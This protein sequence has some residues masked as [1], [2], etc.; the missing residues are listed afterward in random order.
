MNNIKKKGGT[1][2]IK[3]SYKTLKAGS[4]TNSNK[5]SRSQN[6]KRRSTG[7]RVFRGTFVPISK[8]NL[9]KLLKKKIK[10]LALTDDDLLDYDDHRLEKIMT[11]DDINY[12]EL[13]QLRL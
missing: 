5:N 9:Q 7:D 12:I 4:K 8:N 13:S 1:K 2:K 6:T 10:I 3:R 11:D